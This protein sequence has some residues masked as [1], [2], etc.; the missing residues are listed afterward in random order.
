MIH[1]FILSKGGQKRRIIELI[2]QQP[3]QTAKRIYNSLK[4]DSS[5]SF[6]Y[7]SVFKC[8]TEL[9]N[10]SI[11]IKNN[12]NYSINPEWI[13]SQIN[14]FLNLKKVRKNNKEIF[15]FNNISVVILNN[16]KEADNY[17]QSQVVKLS[18][19]LGI[20]ETYWK[21]PH[22]WWLIGY[23]LEEDVAINNYTDNQLKCE[24][25]ICGETK[26]D[27][28]AENYY[29]QKE[30]VKL[31]L[32]K[33]CAPRGEVFQVIDDY[34]FIFEIPDEILKEMD[35]LYERDMSG[36]LL[37]QMLKLITKELRIELK[38][39]KDKHLTDYYVNKVKAL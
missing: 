32:N 16:L 20:K 7:Q 22:C 31:R 35:G 18:N 33:N 24:A 26:L 38:I 36:D 11:L 3:E 21:T 13:E 19:K 2:T 4:R 28:E 27:H 23:P 5:K 39:I 12:L 37:Q 30:G 8:L 25:L 10:D 17:I 14:F 9:I 1:S 6:T 15:N 34:V 29:A